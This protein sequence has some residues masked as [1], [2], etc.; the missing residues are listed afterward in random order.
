V[1][2]HAHRGDLVKASVQIAVVHELEGDR[3][4]GTALARQ[5]QLFA[6]NGD[7]ENVHAIVLR[8]MARQSPPSATDVQ[9]AL[10]RLEFKLAADHVEL[11]T[12]T[13]CRPGS[14]PGSRSGC[15]LL[16][17]FVRQVGCGCHKGVAG[18]Q[19]FTSASVRVHRQA[20]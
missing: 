1:L 2:E 8:G 7:A 9:Q 17:G 12:R 18:F 4:P 20:G 19:A 10:A 15:V 16:F 14:C 13:T 11:V 6:L 5:R 3:Q